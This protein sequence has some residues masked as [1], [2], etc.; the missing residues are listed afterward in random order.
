MFAHPGLAHLGLR[1]GTPAILFARDVS[2]ALSH[3]PGTVPERKRR[4]RIP[5]MMAGEANSV[6]G[7]L[8]T[9]FKSLHDLVRLASAEVVLVPD[10]NV[11]MNHPPFEAFWGSAPRPV[12]AIAQSTYR[13]MIKLASR[14]PRNANQVEGKRKAAMVIKQLA[15]L[16][17]NGSLHR[18]HLRPDSSWILLPKI[19]LNA[20][21]TW[22]G[23]GDSWL[24]DLSAKLAAQVGLPLVVMVTDDRDLKLVAA[25]DQ[26]AALT[27]REVRNGTLQRLLDR[28][29]VVEPARLTIEDLIGQGP[30]LTEALT[31]GTAIMMVNKMGHAEEWWTAEGVAT[32]IHQD[33]VT[34]V[35]LEWEA[36][37][38]WFETVA[39]AEVT[40]T[41]TAVHGASE[42]DPIAI[43]DAF[44]QE[45]GSRLFWTYG[46]RERWLQRIAQQRG[47]DWNEFF[48]VAVDVNDDGPIDIP[49][50][51]EIAEEHWQS[52]AWPSIERYWE[53][54][55]DRLEPGVPVTFAISIGKPST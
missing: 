40:C 8:E 43:H 15:P 55:E 51:L 27:V 26:V 13:E 36:R 31:D 33:P 24:I 50:A 34:V 49:M 10:S 16:V 3:K 44:K 4:A 48:D 52:L 42:R 7:P 1:S 19:P 29:A 25:A 39:E 9:T 5:S 18:G 11:L 32:F 53:F 23:T 35:A 30:P 21:D 47:I 12:V 45:I 6:E 41:T 14:D 17:D 46:S 22:L 20:V 37:V 2:L 54:L 38:P 28:A